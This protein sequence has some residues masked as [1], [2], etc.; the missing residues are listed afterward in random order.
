M[1]SYIY[2][3]KLEQLLHKIDPK[4]VKK[5]YRLYFG[6]SEIFECACQWRY[7]GSTMTLDEAKKEIDTQQSHYHTMMPYSEEYLFFYYDVQ[8]EQWYNRIYMRSE[9]EDNL[10]YIFND[11]LYKLLVLI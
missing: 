1:T 2:S 7:P 4:H 3:E 5:I 10:L 8:W 6:S 11:K 9:N